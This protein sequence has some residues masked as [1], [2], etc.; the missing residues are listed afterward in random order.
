MPPASA[1]PPDASAGA[2]PSAGASPADAAAAASLSRR[3]RERRRRRQAMLDAARAVFAE[4]GYARATLDEIAERAEFGKGTL[5]NYFEGG[6]EAILFAVFDDLY[7]EIEAVIR[8]AMAPQPGRSLRAT[9]H[10]LVVRAFD[11]F[12]AR[13]DLFFILTKEAYRHA[14]G[15]DPE[16]AAYFHAQR[17]R[18]VGALTPAVERALADGAIRPLP[19]HAVAHMLL[20]NLDGLLLHRALAD[21]FDPPPNVAPR[22]AA[23]GDAASGDAPCGG[24]PLTR[25]PDR[26]ADFL[27]TM[28]FDGLLVEGRRAD[29]E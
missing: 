25:S 28:L 26:A 29:A 1:E 10:T 12:V 23:S 21:R 22:A 24:A 2:A 16:R 18:L 20:E 14:L 5:Y 3:E 17:E 13:Q 9:F 19:P 8:E 27:T 4:K 11:F 6:K 7:D 15:D